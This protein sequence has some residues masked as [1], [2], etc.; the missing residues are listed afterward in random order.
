M[1]LA[2]PAEETS[3][4]STRET[5][6]ECD[7]FEAL[8]LKL[9]VCRVDDRV[10][11]CGMR[12]M[13]GSIGGGG[14]LIPPILALL[15]LFRLL[16]PSGYMIAPDH[17][18]RPGLAL[19]AAPAQAASEAALHGG[20]DGQPADPAP[21]KSAEPPCAFAAL[22]APP[23]PPAPP[24]VAPRVSAAAAPPALPEGPA[25]PRPAPA[26]PLPPATGPPL[27]V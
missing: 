13:A 18:G 15:L 20:H 8:S 7:L 17:E 14:G 25:L 16:V 6:S 2:R 22:G 27:S 11:L 1:F 24:A 4:A 26:A 23:L 12:G 9:G 10:R 21:A 5:R 3:W 19:C